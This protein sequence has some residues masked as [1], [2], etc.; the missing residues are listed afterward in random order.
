[1]A[2]KQAERRNR[3]AIP[4]TTT[5]AKANKKKPKITGN[6]HLSEDIKG[7]CNEKFKHRRKQVR[8][9]PDHGETSMLMIQKDSCN[10]NV[11]LT[12]NNPWIQLNSYQNFNDVLHRKK[13]LKFI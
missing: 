7:L 8:K 13:I 9:T 10:K 2:N 1:M 11:Y 3:K 6:K 12:K 5:I 4:F